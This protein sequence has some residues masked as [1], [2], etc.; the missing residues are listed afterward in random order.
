MATSNHKHSRRASEGAEASCMCAFPDRLLH[1]AKEANQLGKDV[2]VISVGPTGNLETRKSGKPLMIAQV[3]SHKPKPKELNAEF[4]THQ[5]C[6]S[7]LELPRLL[8]SGEESELQTIDSL[9]ASAETCPCC[10]IFFNTIPQWQ[11]F[12]PD[13]TRKVSIAPTRHL[14]AEEL[15]LDVFNV[16]S[17]LLL[18]GVQLHFPSIEYG[19][20]PSIRQ[21]DLA[22][23]ARHGSSY[24]ISMTQVQP[25]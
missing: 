12:V 25:N 18:R 16:K 23:V 2:T 3:D 22:L 7:C 14:R 11:T 13:N 5:L 15:V 6:S 1:P 24:G 21:G 8:Q 10:A 20:R 17:G 4:C 19:S 9:H